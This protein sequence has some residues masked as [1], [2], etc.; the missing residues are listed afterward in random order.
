M[1]LT[2]PCPG[3][4]EPLDVDDEH[5][6][7]KVRCP[8]CAAEF[9]PDDAR[10]PRPADALAPRRPRD[11]DEY[12]DRPRRRRRPRLAAD[13]YDDAKRDVYGPSV[14]LEL[15]GW[16]G[17]L[18]S[19]G[20]GLLFL[21]IGM[22]PQ[23]G[24]QAQQEDAIVALIFGGCLGVFGT[25][26]NAVIIYGARHLRRLSSRPWAMTAAI[27]GLVAS[28]F[29]M[30]AGVWALVVINRSHVCDAFAYYAEH[31]GPPHDDD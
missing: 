10:P 9:V 13:D 7:W 22:A 19:L 1:P 12:D 17:V 29:H 15:L 3:C 26:F 2:V 6:T 16:L 5:R 30:A 28:W 14:F 23:Q 18:A 21:V 31:G 25:V 27:V 20:L 24:R 11:D 4:R 8:R